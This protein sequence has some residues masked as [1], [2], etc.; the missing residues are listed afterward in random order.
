MKSISSSKSLHLR[1]SI[2]PVSDNSVYITVHFYQAHLL[3]IHHHQEPIYLPNCVNHFVKEGP[4]LVHHLYTAKN[5]YLLLHTSS[6]SRLMVEF[7]NQEK[8]SI[9][10]SNLLAGILY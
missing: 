4:F 5:V 7:Y 3:T 10:T 2:L 9:L 8:K 1:E 6:Y